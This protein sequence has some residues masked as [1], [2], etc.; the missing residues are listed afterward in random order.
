MEDN[1][2]DYSA[3]CPLCNKGIKFQLK[4]SDLFSRLRGDFAIITLRAHGSPSHIL[5]VY[6]DKNKNIRGTYPFFENDGGS[7]NS[8]DLR[9]NH[10]LDG[11]ADLAV[12]DGQL[13][14][15]EV[16]PYE[17]EIEGKIKRKYL[18]D[19]S[20]A[21]VMNLIVSN[22]RIECNPIAVEDYLTAFRRFDNGKPII[23]NTISSQI[24]K[25]YKNALKAKKTI[26]KINP[27]LG[28]KIFVND[29]NS[30]CPMLKKMTLDAVAMDKKGYRLPEI[31][32][33]LQGIK[34]IH[35]TFFVAES[36]D[37]LKKSNILGTISSLSESLRGTRPIFA[38][39]TDGNGK[40]ESIKSVKSQ[41]EAL[42]EFSRL[43]KMNFR[44][45]N[46]SGII[47]HAMAEGAAL[48]LL[49]YLEIM[50][51]VDKNNF[52]IESVGSTL[53]LHTG[54]G[55]LGMTIFPMKKNNNNF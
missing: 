31:E 4:D 17:I 45:N 11:S 29:S 23:I 37:C 9:F 14:G 42:A 15:V 20:P 33:Y 49:E 1:L 36:L 43:L 52:I 26:E 47:F 35:R 38:A 46:I 32:N 40:I 6:I 18:F 44:G 27:E 8:T 13:L 48:K 3:Q 10:L 22:Q 55:L 51:N 30:I 28:A 5:K 39:N 2:V 21:E 34:N 7:N 19:I 53:C 25:N 12:R 24:S 16:L 50:L 54:I 41:K